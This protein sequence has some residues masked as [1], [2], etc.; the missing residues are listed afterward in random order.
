MRKNTKGTRLTKRITVYCLYIETYRRT[1]SSSS[2]LVNLDVTLAS[3]LA[4]INRDRKLFKIALRVLEITNELVKFVFVYNF[5]RLLSNLPTQS[6]THP[7]LQHFKPDE[8]EQSFTQKC[9]TSDGHS[10][11]GGKT[12][13]TATYDKC[14]QRHSEMPK[15]FPQNA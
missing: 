10:A 9:S 13:H 8:H 1:S 7:V 6:S 3:H 11:G 2:R 4:L 15:H 14:I 5:P 12:G